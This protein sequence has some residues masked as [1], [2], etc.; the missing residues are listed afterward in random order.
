[1][2]GAVHRREPDPEKMLRLPIEE[3]APYLFEQLYNSGTASISLKNT[4]LDDQVAIDY[5]ASYRKAISARLMEAW[6]YLERSGMIMPNPGSDSGWYTFSP[7]AMQLGTADALKAYL[8]E[9]QRGAAAAYERAAREAEEMKARAQTEI[10]AAI[11]GATEKADSILQLAR[12][13][14]QGVSLDDVQKQFAKAADECFSAVKLW[15]TL[16][17]AIIVAFCLILIGF[18]T[19]WA[20]SFASGAGGTGASAAAVYHTVIRVTILTAIAAITTF[21]L[22]VLRAQMH[23]R[24][25]NLHRKR[26]ANSMAAFLGAASPEQRDA[27]LAHVVDAITV[28]GNSGLLP[29]GDETMSPAKVILESVPRAFSQKP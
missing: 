13:T 4:F 23:L 15:A 19:W 1:M 27:I 5:P 24:E 12:Q 9:A 17:V 7:T 14:A 10:D 8:A 26:V 2:S 22:K 11:Q 3:T 28:F 20:P 29:D 16:S 18:V 25:Q 21:C 6:T